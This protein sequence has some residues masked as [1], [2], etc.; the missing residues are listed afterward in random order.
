V[1]FT[2]AG[3]ID[4]AVNQG[5]VE[6]LMAVIDSQCLDAQFD[7]VVELR[8]RCR[9]ALA[10]GVQLWPVA[11]YAD[12]RLALDGDGPAALTG[13]GEL[14]E[15]FMLGPIVEV[16]ASTHSFDRLS[17]FLPVTP[18]AASFAA[19]CVVRGADLTGDPLALRLP[20]IS[21]LPLRLQSWEP[22]YE[23]AEY[24]PDRVRCDPPKARDHWTRAALRS[25]ERVTDAVV[26]DALRDLV[27][28]WLSSSDG[29]VDIAAIVGSAELAVGALGLRTASFQE[30]SGAEAMAHMAWA[31]GSGGARGRRRGAAAGRERAWWAVRAL[32]GLDDGGVM[33]D[34]IGEAVGELRWLLW[35]DSSPET[36][37]HL[38]LAVEDPSEGLA[39]AIAA[40]DAA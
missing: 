13:L 39:W 28:H 32:T 17:A 9:A 8:H 6:A 27:G 31:A 33:P 10:R 37:W 34:E 24:R 26:T 15:R 3:E 7:L 12:Y 29:R 11:A 30:V 36:G 40:V 1:G 16:L 22:K 2:D 20:V 25:G 14:S 4:R 19:E 21:D 23:L 18:D 35:S 38:R 5:D